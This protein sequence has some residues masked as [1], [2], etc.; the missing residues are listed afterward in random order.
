MNGNK[1]HVDSFL[2]CI[3]AFIQNHHSQQLQLL[4]ALQVPGIAWVHCDLWHTSKQTFFF[5]I[6]NMLLTI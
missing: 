5:G 4:L 6:S 3:H 1:F 2:L